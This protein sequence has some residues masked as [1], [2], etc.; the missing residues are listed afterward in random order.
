MNPNNPNFRV[1][2]SD[3]IEMRNK[4]LLKLLGENHE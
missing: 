2:G 4:E 1:G 3:V